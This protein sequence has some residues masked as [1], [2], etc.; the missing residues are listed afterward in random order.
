[1][2][3]TEP[4]FIRGA[5]CSLDQVRMSKSN[6]LHRTGVVASRDG[7]IHGPLPSEAKSSGAEQSAD[8]GGG[9][10]RTRSWAGSIGPEA[11]TRWDARVGPGEAVVGVVKPTRSCT[12]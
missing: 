9:E 5:I 11:E 2:T 6:D 4:E 12:T 7:R 3:I 10:L 1:T 8:P